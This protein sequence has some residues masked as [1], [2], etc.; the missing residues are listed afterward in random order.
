M[1]EYTEEFY[2]LNI[3]AGHHESTEETVGR[4]I[5][6]LRYEIKDEIIMIIVRIV[7]D[8]YQIELKAEEKL[9]RK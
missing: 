1:K 8:A 9:A 5:N 6:G 3:R 7:E 2:R 4:Y